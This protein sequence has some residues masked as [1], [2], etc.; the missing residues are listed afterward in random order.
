MWIRGLIVVN[1]RNKL[2]KYAIVNSIIFVTYTIL[3]FNHSQLITGHDE[4]GLGAALGFPLILTIHS[5][6]VFIIVFI[7]VKKSKA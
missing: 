4:Y 5:I 3:W 6:I 2:T 7:T 1:K